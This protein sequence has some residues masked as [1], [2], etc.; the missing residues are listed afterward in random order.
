MSGDR[1]VFVAWEH[2]ENAGVSSAGLLRFLDEA[3]KNRNRVQFHSLVLLR[4]GKTVC[5]L[6]WAPYDDRTPHSLFS[7][8]KSFCSAAAGFAVAEGLLTWDS[9]VVEVLA[10]DVPGENREELA[11]ITLEHL[12]CMG[13]GLD[14]AS[15]GPPKDFHSS[16]ARHVLSHHTLHKPMEHFHYNTFGTY[17]VSCMVQK[18]TGQTVRDYLMPRLFTPLGIE[19]PDWA[20][21]P[22]GVSCAGGLGGTG[23][24]LPH[25]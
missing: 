14:P 1:T 8:S 2:P 9:P 23:H 11:G 24:P 5:R 6:N 10:E 7:L 21:S 4:H 19:A 12:L 15:D 20:A 13:S 3:E 17:L 25:R 16:W 22:Q 18:V